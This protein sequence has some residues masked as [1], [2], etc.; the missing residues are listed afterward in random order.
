MRGMLTI[1]NLSMLVLLA[2]MPDGEYRWTLASAG[3]ITAIVM[4]ILARLQTDQEKRQAQF[5]GKQEGRQQF[6]QQARK[7]LDDTDYLDDR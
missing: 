5:Q 1:L 3:A 7:Y 6:L 4:Y 2:G